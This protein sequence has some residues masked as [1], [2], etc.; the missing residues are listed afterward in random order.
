MRIAIDVAFCR[1]QIQLWLQYLP[2]R[3][4]YRQILRVRLNDV[5][6]EPG[7]QREAPP[8]ALIV[9]KGTANGAKI[10]LVLI[11][12]LELA[13]YAPVVLTERDLAKFYRLAGVTDLV[14]WDD[15]TDPRLDGV[16]AEDAVR[17]FRSV[18]DLLAFTHGGARVGR[19]AA[20][21]AF[22]GLRVG[23]LDLAAAETTRALLEYLSLGMVRAAAARRLLQSVRP[24]LAL[25]L[26]NRY[27]GQA[28]LWTCASQKG[29]AS[30]P[31][32]KPTAATRSC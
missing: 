26:D 8:K 13:G 25:F 21:T 2:W 12:G 32:S 22:R 14:Y 1:R 28:E 24:R 29:S 16:G 30:S 6:G 3:K 23:H 31:G 5:R 27:T 9:G 7:S 15:F 18:E 11:K 17:S 19:F 10:E 4:K 20:S